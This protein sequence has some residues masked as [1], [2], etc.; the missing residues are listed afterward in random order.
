MVQ[1]APSGR[2][3]FKYCDKIKVMLLR[4]NIAYGDSALEP[5]RVFS[6]ADPEE[7]ILVRIDDK[8]SRIQKG[9]E[10]PEED[11]VENLIGYLI[12]LMVV[13]NQETLFEKEA[14]GLWEE[15]DSGYL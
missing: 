1:S 9:F 11:A 15:D 2:E 3:I 12:L 6:K 4:K 14:R 10:Y 8:L 5:V 7:Q 13:R